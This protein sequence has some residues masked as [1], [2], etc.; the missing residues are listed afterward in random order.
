MTGASLP[1]NTV[2]SYNVTFGNS[3]IANTTVTLSAKGDAVF[4]FAVPR[5]SLAM[6]PA[7]IFTVRTANWTYVYQYSFQLV[8]PDL[9]VIEFYPASGYLTNNIPNTIYFQA[10]ANAAKDTPLDISGASL[11]QKINATNVEVLLLANSINSFAK[12]KGSFQW[13]PI[14][15]TGSL[16]PVFEAV[17]NGVLVRRPVSF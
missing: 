8:N 15:T 2:V 3:T 4:Q 12:G 13:T 7:I 6:N 17:I 1:N 9:M 14:T 16:P 11:K 10:W 5:Y